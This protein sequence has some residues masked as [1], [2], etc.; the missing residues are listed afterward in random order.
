MN[1]KEEAAKMKQCAPDMAAS[2]FETRNRALALIAEGLENNRAA[3]F[4]AN[5]QD[6][7]A[8]AENN[9]APAIVKRL[10]YDETKMRDSVEGLRQLMTLP[11]PAMS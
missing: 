4:E 6:L 11:D 3:I 8:A 10:K 5:A 9:I 7:A 1:M 2:S